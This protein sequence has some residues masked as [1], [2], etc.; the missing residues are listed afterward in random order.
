MRGFSPAQLISD[1]QIRWSE[2]G[3]VHD[4]QDYVRSA[5]A[6]RATWTRYLRLVIVEITAVSQPQVAEIEVYG[7]GHTDRGTFLSDR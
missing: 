3:V 7:T 1:D 4:I 5:A 6:F 2:V